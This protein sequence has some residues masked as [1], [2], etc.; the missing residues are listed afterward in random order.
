MLDELFKYID[1]TSFLDFGFQMFFIFWSFLM[2]FIGLIM[3]G[4]MK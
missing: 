1:T 2:F 4:V 3:R